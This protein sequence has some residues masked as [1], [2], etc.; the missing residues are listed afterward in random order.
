M[1]D[2][3]TVTVN[4]DSASAAIYVKCELLYFI[5]NKCDLLLLDSV[6]MICSDFYTT[7]EIDEA[8][9]IM[10]QHCPTK[11]I[12]KFTG[13]DDVK[14]KKIVQELDGS[15]SGCWGRTCGRQHAS[16]RSQCS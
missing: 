9:A 2:T 14:R 15:N 8:R 5:Q 12:G 1:A 10:T 13:N 6:V 11:R 16:T 4:E 3:P 7:I